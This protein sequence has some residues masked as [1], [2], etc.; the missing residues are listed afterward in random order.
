MIEQPLEEGVKER[1]VN[2]C[3]GLLRLQISGGA[4]PRFAR[5]TGTGEPFATTAALMLPGSL[6]SGPVPSSAGASP[7]L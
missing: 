6:R 7:L 1:S 5:N 3:G 2:V 4:H